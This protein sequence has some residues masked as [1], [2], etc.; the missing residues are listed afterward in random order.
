MAVW[1]GPQYGF[2]RPC[3]YPE[4]PRP[5]TLSGSWRRRHGLR[6]I[7]SERAVSAVCK[8]VTRQASAPGGCRVVRPSTRGHRGLRG[9]RGGTEVILLAGLFLTL[10]GCRAQPSASPA[11]ALA[12]GGS[13]TPGATADEYWTKALQ[14]VDRSPRE[15]RAQHEAEL[16]RG[17]HYVKLMR[18]NPSRRQIALTFD[19]GPHPDYTPRLLA[20]LKRY[21]VKATFFVVGEKAEQ[22]PDLVKQELAPG[23]CVGNHTYHHVNLTRI[24]DRLVAAEIQACGDVLAAITGTPPHLFRPPG[25]DYDALVAR[26]ADQLGYTLVLW[27]DDPGDYARPGTSTIET[28]TLTM[29]RNGGIILIHD[30]VQQTIDVLP[31]LIEN[32]RRRGFE[33]VTVDELMRGK[34]EGVRPPAAREPPALAPGGPR[35]G[36]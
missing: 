1:S 2:G 11:A 24:P 27:T 18:G 16:A 33:F 14:E 6:S 31:R 4:W 21:Q 19:D 7:D 8:A 13:Q 3:R 28:R 35:T 34:C 30:G 17:I 29:A 36:R 22:A 32:L 10:G 12:V 15:L 5:I 9:A 26:T 23:H 25:G 20:I